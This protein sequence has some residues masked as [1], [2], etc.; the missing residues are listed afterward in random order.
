MVLI[1]IAL[2]LIRLIDISTAK[3]INSTFLTPILGLAASALGFYFGIGAYND[4]A[5]KRDNTREDG[6]LA[7]LSSIVL[8]NGDKRIT[9]ATD[10]P[11]QKS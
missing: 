8:R 10:E 5:R 1:I 2:L 4:F 6:P 7:R 3:D 9:K 11:A